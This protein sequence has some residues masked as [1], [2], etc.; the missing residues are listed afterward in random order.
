MLVFILGGSGLIGS[1]IV[2][3]MQSISDK[4]I[5]LDI[6]KPKILNKKI[7]FFK[8][9]CSRLK[10]IEKNL[11]KIINKKGIPDVFINASYPTAKDWIRCDFKRIKLNYL[12]N[13]INIHLNSYCW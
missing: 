3:K 6:K 13:N 8:F 12:I 10:S 2:N 1:E 7:E 9:D 5:I 11:S 4:T